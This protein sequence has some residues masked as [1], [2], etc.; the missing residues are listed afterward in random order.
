[1]IPCTRVKLFSLF[2]WPLSRCPTLPGRRGRNIVKGYGQ[3]HFLE[4]IKFQG[5]QCLFRGEGAT[6]RP[7]INKMRKE[8]MA[9]RAK[10]T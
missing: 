10:T 9:L 2:R 6:S 8:K 1:M 3:E 4:P 5:T 7:I